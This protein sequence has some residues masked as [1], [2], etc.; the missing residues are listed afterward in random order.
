MQVVDFK[1]T[2]E[3][4]ELYCERR[5]DGPLLL[6]IGGGLGDAGVYSAAADI[7]A[8]DYTVVTYDRRGNSRS[9]GD[10]GKD[11]TVAQQARDA[12]AIIAAMGADKANIFGNSA[13]GLIGL[14][15]AASCP[16]FIDFLV[17]H[18]A[19]ALTLLPDADKWVAFAHEVGDRTRTQGWEAAR[20]AWFASVVLP[21]NF[22]SMFPIDYAQRIN[23][24]MKFFFE[25]EFL[26]FSLYTPDLSGICANKVPMVTSAGI[27]SGD[28]YYA[29]PAAI[30]AER[31]GCDVVKFPG[32]HNVFQHLPAE[33]A[34]TLCELFA[35]YK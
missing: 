17:V 26:C 35:A 6:M 12:A 5:G 25:H 1:V 15:L 30:I 28:A 34:A 19:P 11:A 3:G 4:A 7:L 16:Y 32:Y 20:D 31:V 18:E 24:N 27:E 33:F 29:R 22:L 10:R 21:D 2:N 9:S 14:E 8:D 23:G 13:G